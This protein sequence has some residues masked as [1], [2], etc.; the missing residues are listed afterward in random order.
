MC[1]VM[2]NKGRVEL[3]ALF[4]LICIDFYNGR[5]SNSFLI[6]IEY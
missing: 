3:S 4:M 2:E 5:E 6:D 1:S